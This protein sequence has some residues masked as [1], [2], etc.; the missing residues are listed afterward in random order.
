MVSGRGSNGRGGGQVGR[1]GSSTERGGSSNTP[2]AGEKTEADKI[3]SDAA[4]IRESYRFRNYGVAALPAFAKRESDRYRRRA[5]SP[6]AVSSSSSS[7]QRPSTALVVKMEEDAEP[8][9]LPQP[10]FAP[11]DY[12]DDA[13]LE[14]ILPQL[15]VDAGL[16][17]GDFVEERNLNTVVGLVSCSRQ[18]E[19]DKAEEWRRVTEEQGRVFV[20][21]GSDSE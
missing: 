18:R 3:R 12:L 5:S 2:P 8:P 21:L 7:R 4:R 1:G 20:D 15:G 9:R 16:A 14:R 11:G 19:A 6:S 17:P 13:Q 10:N